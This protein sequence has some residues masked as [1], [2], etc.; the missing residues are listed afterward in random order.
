MADPPSPEGAVAEASDLE[1]ASP[2]SAV[3]ELPE[4]VPLAVLQ[5]H[6]NVELGSAI[7]RLADVASPVGLPPEGWERAAV[8]SVGLL[9]TDGRRLRVERQRLSEM[10]YRSRLLSER[11]RWSGPDTVSI[12]YVPSLSS[13]AGPGPRSAKETGDTATTAAPLRAGYA[14]NF[15]AADQPVRVNEPGGADGVTGANGLAGEAAPESSV[16]PVI[17][18][19]PVGSHPPLAPAERNRIRRMIAAAFEQTHEELNERYELIIEEDQGNLNALIGLRAIRTLQISGEPGEG[20]LL[21]VVS[22]ETELDRVEAS[23]RVELDELPLAVVA[24]QALNRGDV[25]AAGDV[26]LQPVAR[27]RSQERLIPDVKFVVGM[28]VKRPLSAGRLIEF[29]DVMQ[30]L[31]I[32]RGDLVELRVV[33]G[34]VTITTAARALGPAAAGEPV[35]VETQSPRKK[36]IGRAVAGGVVEIVT[37]PPTTSNPTQRA[38]VR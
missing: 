1:S 28:E 22:G 3:S 14:A 21:L 26:R 8:A 25:I 19:V 31:V 30:P 18:V 15:A 12:R 37:R 4:A 7:V 32:R 20:P 9:P 34:G 6:E 17:S 5:L 38:L 10:L 11:V 29:E 36:L 27:E 24:T 23:V 33:G 16:R 35:S 2:E 13:A